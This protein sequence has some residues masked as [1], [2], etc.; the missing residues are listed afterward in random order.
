VRIG[1]VGPS[2]RARVAEILRSTALFREEEVEVALEVF[3]EGI[4]HPPSRAERDRRERRA[5]REQREQRVIAE[6]LAA[7][8]T[9]YL[10]LGVF[11]DD[12][13]L[14]GYAAYG[15]TP[16]TD[17]TFDLYWIAVDRAAQGT[18]AGT[19]LLQAVEARLSD[20]GARML[21]IETSARTDY[22]ATRGFYQSRGYEEAA[23]VGA[24]YAP[25]EDRVIL[26]KRFPMS[27]DRGRGV[28]A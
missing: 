23:R 19:M 15:P 3:D 25:D 11:A 24:F 26:T 18:G 12:G 21:V 22:A 1:E 4:A 9:D 6:A 5:E 7:T 10:L 2:D 13:R 27:P 28:L 20:S 17:R 16:A 14:L 8:P